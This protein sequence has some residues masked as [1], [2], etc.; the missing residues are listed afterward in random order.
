MLKDT[1][2][3]SGKIDLRKT[4]TKYQRSLLDRFSDVISGKAAVVKPKDPKSYKGLLPV[5]G[6]KVIVPKRAGEKIKLNKA[7]EITI[8]TKTKKGKKRTRRYVKKARAKKRAEKPAPNKRYGIPL[9]FGDGRHTIFFPTFDELQKFMEGYEY[10][11]W[12]RYV[13]E[14]IIEDDE[15]DDLSPEEYAE[16]YGDIAR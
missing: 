16:K 12:Q 14:E 13:V 9:M 4:P 6:D 11:D 8:E 1:G 10:K 5:K 15:D 2:L 7:G 3:Y